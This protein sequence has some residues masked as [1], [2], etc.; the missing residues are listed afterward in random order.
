MIHCD[1]HTDRLAHISNIHT[2]LHKPIHMFKGFMTR[3]K[4]LHTMTEQLAYLQSYDPNL[5][6]HSFV[7]DKKEPGQIGCY[8]SHHI[9]IKQL[10]ENPCDGFSVIFEDDVSFGNNFDEQIQSIVHGLEETFDIIFLGNLNNNNGLHVKNNIYCIDPKNHLWG[11]HAL[12]INN[13]RCKMIYE[14][15][16]SIRH[17]IDGHYKRCFDL[18]KLNGKVIYPP[19]C[20]QNRAL[21]RTT[22]L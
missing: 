4:N 8:L 11:T 1:E 16:C 10:C 14:A 20:T 19:I 5:Q 13:K 17:H 2:R 9:L 18:G 3:D 12:L 22:I 21:K 7:F 6:F 15:N